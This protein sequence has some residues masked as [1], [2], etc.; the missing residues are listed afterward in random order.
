MMKD[1]SR[2]NFLSIGA[3]TA[4]F[5]DSVRGDSAFA[6]QLPASAGRRRLA[7]RDMFEAQIQ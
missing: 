1:L 7:R 3:K 2:R 4:V 6:C 5:E